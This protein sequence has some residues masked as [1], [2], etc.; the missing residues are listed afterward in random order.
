VI[1]CTPETASN[2]TNTTHTVSCVVTDEFGN[3]V[4]GEDVDAIEDGPGSFVNCADLDSGF[5]Y[6]SNRQVCENNPTDG[7]GTVEFQFTS[8][9]EGTQTIEAAIQ[10]DS[11]T[12]DA[13]D[14]GNA[15]STPPDADDECDALADRDEPGD[16]TNTLP[17]AAAGVCFDQVSKTWGPPPPPPTDCSD[18]VDNDGDGLIDFPADPGCS[19][20]DDTTETGRFRRASSITIRHRNRPHVFRGRVS[21]SPRRCVRGR[22]VVVKKVRPGPDTIV[23]RD[24]TNRRGKWVTRHNRGGRG[25]YYARVLRKRFINQFGDTII[26]RP[27]RSRRIRVR[28]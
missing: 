20:A 8:A 18:G 17:G 27:D 13:T 1:D 25:R 24:R 3:P 23:G 6:G 15:A 19:S 2:Q 21:S 16:T 10:D 12:T 22:R 7:T 5:Y 14:R 9:T 26:C 11:D 4:S 28:R